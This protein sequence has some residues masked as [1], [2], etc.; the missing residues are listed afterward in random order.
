MGPGF[1]F[2][3][4]ASVVAPLHINTCMLPLLSPYEQ[5]YCALIRVISLVW[6]LIRKE[7]GHKSVSTSLFFIYV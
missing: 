2:Q 6:K 5:I 4:N 1:G 3:G 7:A